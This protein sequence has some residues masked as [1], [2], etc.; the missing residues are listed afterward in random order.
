M[1]V[2]PLEM[3][4]EFASETGPETK[5]ANADE[6]GAVG[7]D[8]EAII[9]QY[10]KLAEDRGT[11][12]FWSCDTTSRTCCPSSGLLRLLGLAPTA[13]FRIAEIAD[14]AHP[15][16]R[17]QAENIWLMIRSG[18]PVERRFRIV[19][20]DRTVRWI[21]FRSEVVLDE[22]Q[23]PSRSIGII[24]DVTAQH[25]SRET[26][27]DTLGR[28]RALVNSL[29]TMEWRATADGMPIYS[30]GWTALTGQLEIHVANGSWMDV[31]HP[32]D[33]QRVAA[34][35]GQSVRTLSPYVINHRLRRVTGEYE[36]YHARAVPII[37]KG[38]RS[39]EWLGIIMLHADLNT[40]S[41]SSSDDT[42][43]LTPMQ[44]RAARAML[45]WTL[46]DLSGLSG[47]SVSSIRRIEAEGERA[48]RPASINAI[49]K[50][51]EDHGLRFS[52]GNT[53]SFQDAGGRHSL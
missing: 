12:G 7:R 4:S 11:M 42:H 32:D 46:G 31:I 43:E 25:E 24:M 2:S 21:D 52:E 50:A 26:I 1:N 16:D 34:A 45:Q 14:F 3:L 18:V 38:G 9:L 29:A 48:T 6:R 23:Q 8:S 36:W 10:L 33:R 53:V 37:K 20:A 28:Y 27:E 47:I 13:P 41:G 30:Q 22:T 15:E 39:H 51:F 44:I 49:R 19:R 35:W 40:W 17:A 5:A